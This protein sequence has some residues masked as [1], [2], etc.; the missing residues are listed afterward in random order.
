MLQP[1]VTFP[2]EPATVVELKS[3]WTGYAEAKAA[4]SEVGGKESLP[5]PFCVDAA[6]AA[7][8]HRMDLLQRRLTDHYLPLVK[9]AA[10]RLSRRLPGTVDPDD[11]VG[12]GVFGLLDAIDK[13]DVGRNIRFEIFAPR[14]ITGAMLD[15]L[16][17]LDWTPRLVRS[18]AR[19]VEREVRAF[20]N[21]FGRPP[22]RDEL[23][24]RLS[25]LC[26]EAERIARDG[27]PVLVTSLEGRP[28]SDGECHDRSLI[29][30]IQDFSASAPAAVAEDD[31]LR[32]VVLQDLSRRDRLILML[33]YYEGMTMK[34]VAAVLD[35][36]ESRISQVHKMILEDL[37]EKLAKPTLTPT[38]LAA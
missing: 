1:S 16:R 30:A 11:L 32:R 29:D 3:L 9:T 33:Y 13:F 18:R 25:P 7:M 2:N 5:D 27:E 23:L 36:S 35:I 12:E 17:S 26:E 38:R 10:D 34:E 14:R 21:A 31:D 15:Y 19:K 4:L 20:T 24:K 22:G 8:Q 28:R 37:R 6:R